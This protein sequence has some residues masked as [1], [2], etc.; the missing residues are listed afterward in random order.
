M[1]ICKFDL[2]DNRECLPF[3]RL[4]AEAD[5]TDPGYPETLAKFVV[6]ATLKLMLTHSEPSANTKRAHF[7]L[8]VFIKMFFKLQ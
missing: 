5:R 7:T 8:F 4:V 1:F 3:H 2:R 6:P